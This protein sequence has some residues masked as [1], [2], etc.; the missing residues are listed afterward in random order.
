MNAAPGEVRLSHGHLAYHRLG[1]GEQTVVLLHGLGD[2]GLCWLRTAE[3]LADRYELL[4]VDSRGHGK[5]SMPAPNQ[6]DDPANDLT[7][8]LDALGLD[9]VCVIG[10]SIGA[11]SAAMFAAAHNARVER[12][13]LEDP[14]LRDNA[15]RPSPAAA[16]GFSAQMASL[17]SMDATELTA[18]GRRQHPT[19]DAAE[20]IAWADAKRQVNPEIIERYRFPA[21]Q[22][23][24]RQ[25]RM[26]TLVVHGAP[27][28]D[29]AVSSERA[30]AMT[31]LNAN[32][33]TVSVAD[34]GHNVR[35]ENFTDYIEAV[36]AFL[37]GP[38]TA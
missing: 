29:S 21:W 24:M 31:A 33:N 35:R 37:S 8:F 30:H 14:P 13:V 25:I 26:P 5:S 17:Q 28:S 23:V 10:H 18:F 34:A 6:P 19:W 16:A 22:D 36:G 11:V 27:G 7:E 1:H 4:L 32:I 3:A 20:F 12:L 15:Y 38:S 9:R 2:S